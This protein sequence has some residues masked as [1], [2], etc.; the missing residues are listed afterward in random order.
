MSQEGEALIMRRV[1][2]LLA[3]LALV[4]AACSKATKPGEAARSL[5]VQVDANTAER[6]V[7]GAYTQFFPN[8]LT[9]HPGDTVEFKLANPGEPHTVTLGRLVTNGLA[10]V[11]AFEAATPSPSPGA[12]E[13]EIPEL[14]KLPDLITDEFEVPQ[15]AGQPCFLDAE[16]PAKDACPKEKQ[17]QPAFSGTEVFY[18][19]GW[20]PEEGFVFR[21]KLASDI[22]PGA[23]GFM[24]LLHREGM[25][26]TIT[27]VAS[28]QTADTPAAVTKRGQEQ[29]D[30]LFNAVK[31]A[32][33][34]GPEAFG[35]KA[36][37]GT[38]TEE[39]GEK[40]LGTVFLPK[41]ISIPTGGTVTWTVVGPHTISLNAPQDA[42]G[43]LVKQADGTVTLNPKAGAPSGGPGAPPPS[44]KPVA[45]DGGAW[46][47]QGFRS[48][49]IVLSFPPAFVTFKLK[50]TTA[51]TYKVVCLIH[52]DMEGTVKVG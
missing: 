26:G 20:L 49:G 31:A 34:K 16:P 29:L 5:A 6:G 40:A 51:G 38:G 1:L 12:E 28:S 13:P 30:T 15:S 21:V 47:G 2:V 32:A 33:D 3:V 8:E 4:G 43:V 50:F 24:C 52:P 14:A 27:V 39:L 17:T 42:V 23:Y 25:S 46:N 22:A 35:A 19:S 11:K 7:A 41:E 10:K 45:V 18:N 36:I 44:D 48:T 37:A 9:A